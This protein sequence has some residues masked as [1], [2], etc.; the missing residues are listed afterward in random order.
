MRPDLQDKVNK[1]I[2]RLQTFC[3]PEG[4]YLAF[5]G[6]KDSCVCK[7]LLDMA[8]C[9]YDAHYRVTGIDPPEL[10]KFIKEFHPDV[11]REIPR[12]ADG[13]P[14]TMWNLIIKHKTP[15]T[16][17]IRYCCAELKEDGGDGRMVVT[18]V[19]WA[20]SKNRRDNQGEVLIRTSPKQAMDFD[21]NKDFK[22]NQKGGVILVNDNEESRRMIEQC[23]KRSKTTVNPI[24]EWS[25]RDVWDFIKEYDIPYCSLYDEGFERLGCIGCPMAS[26]KGRDR[27][28]ARWPKTLNAY[29]LAFDKMLRER[30]RRGLTNGLWGDTAESVYHWW[31]EDGVLPGQVN[32][33]EEGDDDEQIKTLLLDGIVDEETGEVIFC[34]DTRKAIE[35]LQRERTIL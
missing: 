35:Q 16:R 34:N 27:E 4:Y 19:R 2:Q 14:V 26:R 9:K 10:V 3:P 32:M 23:Y 13:K 12:Y 30:E 1:S 11:S 15:P 5:S 25:D 21:G 7:A 20:E 24:I 22:S 29:L 28:F 18:G 6:G 31:M 33:F 17:T 8:G